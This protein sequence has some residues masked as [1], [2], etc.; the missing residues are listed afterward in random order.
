MA[1]ASVGMLTCRRIEDG[2]IDT[3]VRIEPLAVDEGSMYSPPPFVPFSYS[4]SLICDWAKLLSSKVTR[5]ER[6]IM[7]GGAVTTRGR[8]GRTM[9]EVPVQPEHHRWGRH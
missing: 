3:R 1:V 7:L 2:C 6:V 5:E 9:T 4:P 8:E